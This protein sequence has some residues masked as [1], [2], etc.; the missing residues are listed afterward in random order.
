MVWLDIEAPDK[1]KTP[2]FESGIFIW[3]MVAI[4]FKKAGNFYQ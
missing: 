2:F 4:C 3:K 1:L